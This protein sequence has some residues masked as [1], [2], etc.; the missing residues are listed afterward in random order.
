MGVLT[1][2]YLSV[3]WCMP[4]FVLLCLSGWKEHVQND[5]LLCELGQQK[6]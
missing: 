5:L 3:Y 1:V 6:T 2:F 4:A